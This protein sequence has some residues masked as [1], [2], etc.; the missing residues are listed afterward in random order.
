MSSDIWVPRDLV[1]SF[2]NYS[3]RHWVR[4]LIKYQLDDLV[5]HI[6]H[7]T[8]L[9]N[10]KNGWTYH[11]A[12]PWSILWFIP[13]KQTQAEHIPAVMLCTRG[14]GSGSVVEM[15]MKKVSCGSRGQA[16]AGRPLACLLSEIMSRKL[17]VRDPNKISSKFH[18]HFGLS[19][20]RQ[21]RAW[22]NSRL[23]KHKERMVAIPQVVELDVI[24]SVPTV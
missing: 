2:G 16:N 20:S 3:E 8:N 17:R 5:Y 22:S 10:I 15:S 9:W 14:A 4:K 6:I 11:K 12:G 19:Y 7:L 18:P 23:T 13:G 21:E 24:I 1:K